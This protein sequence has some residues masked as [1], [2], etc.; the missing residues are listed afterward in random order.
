VCGLYSPPIF[1]YSNTKTY[2]GEGGSMT[3]FWDKFDA[4]GWSLWHMNY[5][6]NN[7]NTRAFMAANAITG[8]LQRSDEIRKWAF[9]V[10]D[11]LGS[12]ESGVLEIKG[13]WFF[14][15]DTPQYIKDA[16]DDANWY[17]WT[18]LAGKD[19]PITDEAK[20]LVFDYWTQEEELEG[21]PIQDSKVF[22]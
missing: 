5:D 20:K 21:K 19:M 4:S 13:V 11:L 18:K 9:G 6:Y 14:R 3:Y 17:T 2:E 7:E 15:G 8:F 16:N 12:E 10:M 1:R 22:K